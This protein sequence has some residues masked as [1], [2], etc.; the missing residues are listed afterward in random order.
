[1]L[2][3]KLFRLGLGR[4]VLS[5]QGCECSNE[6]DWICNIVL[7]EPFHRFTEH[8]LGEQTRWLNQGQKVQSNLSVGSALSFR[9]RSISQVPFGPVLVSVKPATCCNLMFQ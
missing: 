3:P 1:M 8:V 9:K 6:F 2:Q 5:S 4:S 7:F